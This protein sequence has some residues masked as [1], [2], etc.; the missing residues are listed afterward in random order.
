MYDEVEINVRI[1]EVNYN[2]KETSLSTE[3]RRSGKF[4]L[5]KNKLPDGLEVK[6]S[7]DRMEMWM[8]F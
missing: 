1:Q 8:K 7:I 2:N 6:W 5:L 4:R 3:K